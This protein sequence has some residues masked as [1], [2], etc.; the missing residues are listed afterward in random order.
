LK[1]LR[2]RLRINSFK[3]V[4]QLG[5]FNLTEATARNVKRYRKRKL[6]MKNELTLKSYS[7]LGLTLQDQGQFADA[8][9]YAEKAMKGFQDLHR[10]TDPLHL[11]ILS[12][13]YRLGALYDLMGDYS[14]SEAFLSEAL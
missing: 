14:K 8:M 4:R 9:R 6:G 5:L 1:R 13:K 3:I 12:S 2:W 11:D 7:R 10:A